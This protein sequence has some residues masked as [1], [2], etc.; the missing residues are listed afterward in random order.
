V[1]DVPSAF[2]PG[3]LTAQTPTKIKNFT[4][5]ITGDNESLNLTLAAVCRS[6]QISCETTARRA[7]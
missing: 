7:A 3:C 4:T 1:H 5:S 6:P 2:R